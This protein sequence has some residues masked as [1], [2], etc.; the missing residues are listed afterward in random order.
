MDGRQVDKLL[1]SLV[2]VVM[3][4]RPIVTI[5]NV[6]SMASPGLE[7]VAGRLNVKHDYTSVIAQP[8]LSIAIKEEIVIIRQVQVVASRVITSAIIAKVI[9][10]L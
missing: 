4:P 10:S 9:H 8:S 5:A 6:A 1:C 2:I 7:E 3:L